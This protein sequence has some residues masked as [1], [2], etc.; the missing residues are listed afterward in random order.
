MIQAL[1][2]F[3]K[4]IALQPDIA[5]AYY[6]RGLLYQGQRQHQFAID[7]FSTAIG[8][9]PQQADPLIARGLS[10]LAVND[11]KSAAG[12]LDQAVLM[13]Q[14]NA[15]AWMSRG[16]RLRAARRPQQGGRL[17]R[18]GDEAPTGLRARAATASPASAARPAPPTRPSTDADKCVFG[19][20]R[21]VAAGGIR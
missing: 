7:D 13:D 6:N 5:Q 12:D 15:H 20:W 4:A 11:L 16:A 18:A 2:D 3:N 19:D 21:S 17:L 1:Q 14:Q 10:Y 9:A 8:L